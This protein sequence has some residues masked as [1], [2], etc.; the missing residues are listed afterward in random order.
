MTTVETALSFSFSVM[1]GVRIRPAS[2]GAPGAKTAHQRMTDAEKRQRA[3]ELSHAIQHVLSLHRVAFP[4]VTAP[5]APQPPPADRA[6]VLAEHRRSALRGIG[7]FQFEARRRAKAA[8]AAGAE[9]HI[10]HLEAERQLH[11]QRAQQDLDHWWAALLRNDLPVVLGVLAAAF[12]DNE[13]P[14]TVAGLDGAE[15]SLI[16]LVPGVDDMP[17]RTPDTTAAGNLTLRK[18]TKTERAELH[19]AAVAS[20]VLR[21]VREAFAVA[22]GLVAA[23]IVA[24]QRSGEDAYGASE[25]AVML[26]AKFERDRLEGVRW[27]QATAG[28]ILAEASSELIVNIRRGTGEL[29]PLDIR[30]EP[31]LAAVLEHVEL[32]DTPIGEPRTVPLP[33]VIPAPAA[34]MVAPVVAGDASPDR[35]VV[36]RVAVA[37]AWLLVLVMAMAGG[38]SAFLVMLALPLIVVGLVAVIAGRLRWAWIANRP[39][40]AGTLAAGFVVLILAGG[41]AAP[42]DPA[43]PATAEAT[44]S[45][46]PP[47]TRSEATTTATTV[48]STSSTTVPPPPVVPLPVTQPPQPPVVPKPAPPPPPTTEEPRSNC[49]PSY[50]TVCIPPPPPDLNCDDV[51]HRRF[52][53]LAPDPHGFDGNNDGIGCES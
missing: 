12:A 48:P 42:T 13:A 38:L 45:T 51:P 34:T 18:L 1:P 47:T 52:V 23:R 2:F 29:R 32:T 53:V 14:A 30:R 43:D 21:T 25:F 9:Q 44:T 16:A 3:A 7:P 31:D 37:V 36:V 22:P 26:A 10:A 39:V 33:M 46:T 19:T 50:P 15:V 35:V 28:V 27:Q 17:E 24:L 4:T 5:R 20:H 49:D 11:W 41:V 6:V 8:A 40:G